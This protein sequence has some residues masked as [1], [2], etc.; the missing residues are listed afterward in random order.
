[1]RGGSDAGL[2]PCA[3]IRQTSRLKSCDVLSACFSSRVSI[4]SWA[5]APPDTKRDAR[6]AE[7]AASPCSNES[8]KVSD[9]NQRSKLGAVARIRITVVWLQPVTRE[10]TPGD[11]RT[12]MAVI[13]GLVPQALTRWGRGKHSKIAFVS[14]RRAP[15]RRPS[16]PLEQLSPLIPAQAGIQVPV[17]CAGTSGLKFPGAKPE[18][19]VATVEQIAARDKFDK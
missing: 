1:M 17:S 11:A 13:G 8:T 9:G 16:P 6:P 19:T 3:A 4:R 7:E 2:C 15:N 10:H 5:F 18:S 12:S 14:G